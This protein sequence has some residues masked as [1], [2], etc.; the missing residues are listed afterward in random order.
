MHG[1]SERAGDV[2]RALVTEN[3]AQILLHTT[4][5]LQLGTLR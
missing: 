1:A 3:L 5:A 4:S 2:R